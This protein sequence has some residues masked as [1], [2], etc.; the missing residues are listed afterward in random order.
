M[1]RTDLCDPERRQGRIVEHLGGREVRYGDGDVVK[2][3]WIHH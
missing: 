3:G 1:I 2:H